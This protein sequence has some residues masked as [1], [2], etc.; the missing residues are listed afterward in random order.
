M[1]Y[2]RA[3]QMPTHPES[4]AAAQRHLAVFCCQ[5]S[6]GTHTLVLNPKVNCFHRTNGLS[7]GFGRTS[8]M[9]ASLST[10]T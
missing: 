9:V 8:A 3:R 2:C 7:M 5:P 10:V 4:T 6:F 1:L